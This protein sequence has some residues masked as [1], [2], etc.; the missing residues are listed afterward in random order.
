MPTERPWLNHYPADVD[1]NP[2]IPDKPV[3]ALL[4]ESAAAHPDLPAVRFYQVRLTYSQL[5]AQ[6]QRA[7]AAF[8]KAG[9]RPG[10]RVGLMLP[11]CPQ[12]IMAY[13]GALR[14]GAIVVQINP[15]YTARELQHILNNAGAET[16]VVADALYP[17]VQEAL[18]ATALKRVF[19][20]RLRGE[21]M[22]GPEARSFEEALAAAS[23][24]PPVVTVDNGAVAVLQYTGGTTGVSKGAML[25]HRN[26]VA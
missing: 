16:I 5:W 9:V 3:Y 19:A 7:A 11:N 18:S 1:P 15:L 22:L 26:L 13:F 4:K 17:V 23:D 20:T 12:Y 14:A 8:A 24:A 25:T 6:A 10:D 2:A 21:V